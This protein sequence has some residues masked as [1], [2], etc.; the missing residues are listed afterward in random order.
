[1]AIKKLYLI[2]IISFFVFAFLIAAGYFLL[3]DILFKPNNFSSEN[4]NNNPG[5]QLND[6]S[7]FIGDSPAGNQSNITCTSSD[8]CKVQGVIN[9]GEAEPVCVG[10][11]CSCKTDSSQQGSFV[12]AS[13]SET[14][15]FM[16]TVDDETFNPSAYENQEIKDMI[17]TE[18]GQEVIEMF[19][20]T[21]DKFDIIIT[22]MDS[23]DTCFI[24]GNEICYCGK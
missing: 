9:C 4:S 3:K 12:S 15:D 18:K 7:S 11:F 16:E 13:C 14:M 20:Y 24:S 17:E 22:S 10:G 8:E 19:R 6:N 21:N 2:L 23:G 5:S 1:M